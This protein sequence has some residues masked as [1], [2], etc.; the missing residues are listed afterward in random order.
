MA[1]YY[2]DIVDIVAPSSAVAGE[3]VPVT[4]RVK[5]THTFGFRISVAVTY[6]PGPV[7]FIGPEDKWVAAGATESWS[8][9][10]TMPGNDV[11]IW[12][13]SSYWGE[14]QLWH[15]DDED[16]KDISLAEVFKGTISKKELEHDGIRGTIPVS[17]V[18]Q[19]RRGLV[20]IWGRN[21]MSSAQRMGIIWVVKDPDNVT[22]EDYSAWEAWPY[23]GA[24]KEHEFIGGRFSLDKAGTWKI[25]VALFIY[26]E[27]SIAVDA[28]YGDLCTVKAAV[29][30]PEFRDF[31]IE[32]YITV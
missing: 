7:R 31:G 11:T 23:T 12:A 28:Y 18:P 29:P 13:Y 3:T 5:N 32:K 30:E 25:V 8:G 21:D 4:V 26:P 15:L 16:E 6:V 27:G 20:H 17:N 22:R 19:G 24:G 10:F 2:T 1:G 9:S 14:D